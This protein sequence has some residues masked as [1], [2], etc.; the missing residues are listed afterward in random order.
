[1]QHGYM[2]NSYNVIH[3]HF[4]SDLYTL[5]YWALKQSHIIFPSFCNLF[6]D[7]LCGFFQLRYILKKTYFPHTG[8]SDVLNNYG[9]N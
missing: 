5:D 6:F 2:I 4:S 7:I 9:P 3:C 1:M 8:N